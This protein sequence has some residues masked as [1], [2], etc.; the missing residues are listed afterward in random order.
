[1][2][3]KPG[4]LVYPYASG[5]KK[6]LKELFLYGVEMSLKTLALTC[7]AMTAFAA[8][9]IFCRFALGQ[10]GMDAG[11]FTL[12]RLVSGA[13]VLGIISGKHAFRP[14]V[15]DI[16]KPWAM[17]LMLALYA[18]FFSYAYVNLSTGTGA[19][20]LFG[21]VQ[22]TM[23]TAGVLAGERPGLIRILGMATALMGLIY[24]VFPGLSA[25]SPLGAF[26]MTLAGI[27][28]GIYSLLGKQVLNPVAATA[29]NFIWAVPLVIAPI[30][31]LSGFTLPTK[32]DGSGFWAAI[33]SGTLASGIG[34]VV[35][36]AAIK[37]L[38]PGR[39]ASVQLTVPVIAA[40]GGIL[41]LA[42]PVSLRLFIASAIILSG[43]G[44]AL[45]P[46]KKKKSHSK[47]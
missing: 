5:I 47:I 35:W 33:L 16:G 45:V 44:V 10:G 19:L 42:E 40:A 23:I 25:P 34:Y 36:Y 46:Q 21:A 27:S 2:V 28:W 38:S 6:N 37:G 14:P 1:M 22:T 9:S 30:F 3:Y 8:N 11:T 26:L 12:I 15:T 13:I 17:P 41:F 20:I 24:L 39:A 32:L 4:G 43:V 18:L 7:L 29:F 31:L